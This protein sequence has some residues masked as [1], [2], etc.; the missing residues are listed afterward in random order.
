MRV[1]VRNDDGVYTLTS[2][3]TALKFRSPVGVSDNSVISID[4]AD[5]DPFV[6]MTQRAR[7]AISQLSPQRMLSLS[8]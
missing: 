2:H 1:D 5:H 6:S 7:R 8:A 3:N 4:S